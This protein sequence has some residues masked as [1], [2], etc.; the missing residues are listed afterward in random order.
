MQ[1]L[2]I[3]GCSY[4]GHIQSD[5]TNFSSFQIHHSTQIAKINTI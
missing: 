5:R 2:S 1:I 4:I 3:N